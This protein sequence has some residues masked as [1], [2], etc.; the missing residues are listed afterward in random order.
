MSLTSEVAKYRT[1][2]YRRYHAFDEDKYFQPNDE[3]AQ[4]HMGNLF[5]NPESKPY[6]NSPLKICSTTSVS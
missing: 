4:E 2:N 5:A 1:E 3:Q 6:T